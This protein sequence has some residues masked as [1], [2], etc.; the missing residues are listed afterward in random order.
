MLAC[1]A[2]HLR[3]QHIRRRLRRNDGQYSALP[4]SVERYG[5]AYQSSAASQKLTVSDEPTSNRIIRRPMRN[6][7]NQDDGRSSSFSVAQESRHSLGNPADSLWN[8]SGLCRPLRPTMNDFLLRRNQ[9]DPPVLSAAVRGVVWRDEVRLAKALRNQLAGRYT[10]V[11]EIG[12]NC[13]RAP[14]G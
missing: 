4:N 14:L 10:L 12:R 8:R 5:F 9:L 11:L 13:V 7:L 1:V 6:Q 2:S 3:R